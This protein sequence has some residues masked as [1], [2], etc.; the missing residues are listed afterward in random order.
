MQ[1][2]V[3]DVAKERSD[4]LL[5]MK[6]VGDE[7]YSRKLQEVDTDAAPTRVTPPLPRTA[8]PHLTPLVRALPVSQTTTAWSHMPS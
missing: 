3:D 8:A 7:L 6:G 5:V 1:Q 2:V 4:F